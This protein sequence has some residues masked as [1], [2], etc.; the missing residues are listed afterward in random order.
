LGVANEIFQSRGRQ[1]DRLP[2]AFARCDKFCAPATGQGISSRPSRITDVN[3]RG[4][5]LFREP[6]TAGTTPESARQKEQ[7]KR[8]K[9]R[10]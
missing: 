10:K 8:R 5:L 4:A 2:G 1:V 9:A 7:M 3:F 6:W